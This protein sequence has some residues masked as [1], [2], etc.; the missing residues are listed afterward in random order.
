[1]VSHTSESG[2]TTKCVFACVCT[3]PPL[4]PVCLYFPSCSL[5]VCLSQM[6]GRGTLKHSSGALY[7]GEFKDNMYHG[8]GTYTFPDGSI[9]KGQFHENR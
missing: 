8:A 2:M 3:L 7:E 1:M 4:M 6:H 9:Y 5:S